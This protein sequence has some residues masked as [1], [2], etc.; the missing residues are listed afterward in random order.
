[1]HHHHHHHHPATVV[2]VTDTRG[3]AVVRQVTTTPDGR[4]IIVESEHH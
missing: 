3:T 2:K 4:P 1:V